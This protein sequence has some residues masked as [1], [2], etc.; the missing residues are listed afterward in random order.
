M[1]QIRRECPSDEE[2]KKAV[3]KVLLTDPDMRFGVAVTMATRTRCM[4]K[5]EVRAASCTA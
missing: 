5:L 1:S 2:L 3:T 4:K